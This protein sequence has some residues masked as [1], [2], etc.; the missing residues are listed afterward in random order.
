ML[1]ILGLEYIYEMVSQGKSELRLDMI[2]T[3]GRI[4]FE[5]FQNFQLEQS[6]SFTLHIDEGVGTAGNF[7]YADIG[8]SGVINFSR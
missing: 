3:N 1:L 8:N 5:T 4:A 6:P 7:I 2:S